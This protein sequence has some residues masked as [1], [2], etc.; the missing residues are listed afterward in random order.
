MLL[1]TPGISYHRGRK[2]YAGAG[3]AF[4]RDLGGTYAMEDTDSMAIVATKRGGFVDCLGGTVKTRK[5]KPSIKALSWKQVEEIV[6]RFVALNPYDRHA[7]PGSILKI[8]D[9]NFDP[10]TGTQRQLYC[11]AISA[12]RYTLF[13]LDRDGQPVM[14][15]R[16][17]NNKNDRWSQHGLG[18][19]LNPT[20]PDCDDRDW[21][22]HCWL[23]IV[24]RALGFQATKL[25]CNNIPAVG[26]VSVSSPA[27]MRAFG[28]FNEGKCYT[29]QIKPFNFVLTC[30]VR[31]LGHPTGAS[32]E[33]FHLIAP[34]SAD[35]R[36][37][38]KHHWT[39]Q[40]TGELCRI[41]TEGH[42]GGLKT[43]RVKTYGEILREY[44]FHP[45][46]KCADADGNACEK[47]TV[48]LLQRRHIEI[49]LVRYIGKES[50]ALED[51]EAGMI[52]S[53]VSVYTEYCDPDRSEWQTKI[54]PALKCTPLALLVRKTG[55]SRRMLIYARKGKFRPHAKHQDLITSVLKK[56]QGG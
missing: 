53:A 11:F 39:N 27:V 19:L 1:S 12:K 43:A 28:T 46:S 35:S 8:E 36:L 2:T 49:D 15:R 23:N 52:H 18:H 44:E 16:D 45:E 40:Y 42:H 33:R 41:T 29:A 3:R 14:L 6:Q 26:R 38:L 13:L 5:R 24:R 34:Y 30:Q 51:V 56:L 32:P 55:L 9:D 50:N 4:G 17:A 48:G 31:A 47:Q 7:V 54:M 10:R 20:D 25:N 22:G 37:W 21:I